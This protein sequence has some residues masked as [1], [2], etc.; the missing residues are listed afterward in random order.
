MSVFLYGCE[1]WSLTAKEEYRLM[2][3]ENRVL[4][5]I[6][7]R[8]RDHVTVALGKLYVHSGDLHTSYS[9]SNTTLKTRRV[10]HGM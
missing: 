3:F 2:V 9:S 1:T 6:F 4:A 10:R 8:K 7:W 5:R